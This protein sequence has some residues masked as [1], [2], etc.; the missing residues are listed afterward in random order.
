MDLEDIYKKVQDILEEKI[1]QILLNSPYIMENSRDEIIKAIILLQIAA[2]IIFVQKQKELKV[3][4]EDWRECVRN[5]MDGKISLFVD[6]I[7][8]IWSSDEYDVREN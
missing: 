6:F 7:N 5:L 8:S 4:V 1:Q 3:H 2:L